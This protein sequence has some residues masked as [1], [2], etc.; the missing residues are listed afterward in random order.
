MPKFIEMK[1]KDIKPL[2][3]KIWKENGEQC[4]VLAKHIPLDKMVLDHKHKSLYP[5]FC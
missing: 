3:E 5:L 2:K 1:G 4:P